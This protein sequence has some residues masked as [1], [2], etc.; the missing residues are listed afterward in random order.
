MAENQAPKFYT[1]EDLALLLRCHPKTVLRRI[2]TRRLIASKP[3]G[4]GYWLIPESEAKR[5]LNDGVNA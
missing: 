2:W 4:Q 1:V 5:Y 3:K